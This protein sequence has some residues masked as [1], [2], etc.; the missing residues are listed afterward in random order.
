MQDTYVLNIRPACLPHI[1][2]L[3]PL[4]CL[5]DLGT[6]IIVEGV[7]Y[8]VHKEYFKPA[9]HSPLQPL[10]KECPPPVS[11][12]GKPQRQH[13]GP[14]YVIRGEIDSKI[15]KNA[16]V[17]FRALCKND[18]EVS[19]YIGISVETLHSIVEAKGRGI[20]S[21]KDYQKVCEGIQEKAQKN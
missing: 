17:Q 15:K 6:H 8:P 4:K 2:S 5:R 11:E 19:A 18:Y 1:P 14:S 21:D 3:T 7:K 20:L 9:T 13:S 12:G 16:L 10:D